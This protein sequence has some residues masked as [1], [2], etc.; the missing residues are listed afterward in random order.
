MTF[1]ENFLWGAAAAA[2]QIEG[3]AFEGGRGRS[4]WD[5]FCDTPGKV[6]LGHTGAIACDHYHRHV[7]DV[8][9]MK[10]MGL[11][12]YR[13]SISWPRVLPTGE[14]LINEEGLDFYDRLIDELL[15]QGIT[16]YATLFHWDFPSALFE[17]GGWLARDSAAWFGAYTDVVVRRLGDRV[18]HWI[19]LNE[20]QVYIQHG[21]RDGTHAPGLQLPLQDQLIAAHNTMR[22]HGHSVQAI[23]AASP[24]PA[25]IGYTGVGAAGCPVDL[26]PANIEAARRATN[27]VDPA[28]HFNNTWW[29]DPICLGSYP[30]AGLEVFG[31]DM[32][33]FPDT[34]FDEMNQPIEFIGLNIYQGGYIRAGDDG[35]P[36]GIPL[37]DG[38]P[39]TTFDW[40]VVPEALRWGPFFA[41]ERYGLPVFITE[42]GLASMDWVS[43]DGKVHDPNR[44]DFTA[45]YLEQLR[46]AIA[47]GADI[48]GYFHWSI[49]DNFEWAKG[50]TKRFGLVHVDYPTGTRTVK[51]SGEWY[52]E[53]IRTNGASIDA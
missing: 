52:A 31:S 33:D 51:D 29:Y 44:I 14:G 10:A 18:K 39:I 4:V 8:A 6:E 23:R 46:L 42:N 16:P 9:I 36:V 19:T 7:E 41:H 34:D 5:D 15:R 45:R 32:P 12:A 30:E 53:V 37:G 26:D 2:Y 47:D 48:R 13:L 1:P 22:A 28:H 50:Y 21:H 25:V 20:P 49:L 3:A 24:G 27:G 38:H 43:R 40:P 11:H 35:E 17:R